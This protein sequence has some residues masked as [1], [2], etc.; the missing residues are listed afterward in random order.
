M[1]EVWYSGIADSG[2][3]RR[4][5]S[6]HPDHSLCAGSTGIWLPRQWV[7][8]FDQ[9]AHVE[10]R[11]SDL[12]FWHR[13]AEAEISSGPGEWRSGFARYDRAWF[14]LRCLQPEDARGTQRR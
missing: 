9:R 12:E 5:R 8:V 13:G 11:D 4:R 6:R 3:I 14:R 1:R 7:T 2:G 10:L